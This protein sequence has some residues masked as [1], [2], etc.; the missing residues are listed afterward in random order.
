MCQ[1]FKSLKIL[2]KMQTVLNE[3]LKIL[4]RSNEEKK[5]H[6]LKNKTT[7]LYEKILKE[8]LGNDLIKNAKQS[9]IIKTPYKIIKFKNNKY[10]IGFSNNDDQPFVVDY[11]FLNVIPYLKWSNRDGYIKV[12][13]YHRHLS[14]KVGK[15]NRHLS[16]TLAQHNLVMNKLTFNGI[17]QKTSVDH[18]NRI[19]T[20]NRLVNLR[21]ETQNEQTRNQKM[22]VKT[23]L[24][25][26]CDISIDEIPR[27]VFYKY[28]KSDDN[29]FFTFRI[30]N[31]PGIGNFEKC[32][33][34]GKDKRLVYKFEEIKA[35]VR[36]F[37]NKYPKKFKL[38]HIEYEKTPKMVQ[39]E[40]EYYNIL[41]LAGIKID[42]KTIDNLECSSYLQ[43]KYDR[44][45]KTE[46]NELMSTNFN[47]VKQ[48]KK[49]NTIPQNC[50]VTQEMIKN[51]GNG[52]IEFRAKSIKRGAYFVIKKHP[53][54]PKTYWYGSSA[55][56]PIKNK[57]KEAIIQLKFLENQTS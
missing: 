20:D 36:F 55:N 47:E 53:N 42:K 45:T 40:K 51:K 50:E 21:I 38:F 41:K 34:K 15:Y 48:I 29:E 52:F 16:I 31:F 1:F 2:F 18:I 19:K 4:G 25:E 23:R 33:S 57:F 9:K 30:K 27:C 44:L 24:P 7:Q 46:L 10:I 43:P 26:N 49:D 54:Y 13:K 3:T 17:G 8:N 12:G 35:F 37:K 32:S 5:G 28:Q 22:K 6:C 56:K 14:I 11:K 39:L